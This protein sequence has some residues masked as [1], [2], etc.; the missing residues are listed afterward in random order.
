MFWVACHVHL[1][2]LSFIYDAF[3]ELCFSIYFGPLHVCNGVYLAAD[4]FKMTGKKIWYTHSVWEKYIS[5]YRQAIPFYPSAIKWEALPVDIH[6]HTHLDNRYDR[7]TAAGLN[8][9]TAGHSSYKGIE[10][11]NKR[12]EIPFCGLTSFHRSWLWKF[13]PGFINSFTFPHVFAILYAFLCTE[14]FSSAEEF[15][16]LLHRCAQDVSWIPPSICAF[17]LTRHIFVKLHKCWN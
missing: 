5:F 2:V 7:N 13:D 4:I 11:W 1:H 8:V 10:M 14:C 6:I 9:T 15:H 16:I 3:V 17:R 12:L